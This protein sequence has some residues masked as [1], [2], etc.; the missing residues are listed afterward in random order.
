M[1]CVDVSLNWLIML[2][3]VAVCVIYHLGVNYVDTASRSASQTLFLDKPFVPKVPM[4]R[5]KSEWY[6]KSA[7]KT[8]FQHPRH[9]TSFLLESLK[10]TNNGTC[11]QD[12]QDAC[13]SVTEQITDLEV[14][15]TENP[16]AEVCISC[17][18]LIVHL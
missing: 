10:G 13:F 6:H 8:L 2:L 14:F 17:V 18:W 1:P 5:E 4:P 16:A 3:Y 12:K 7:T 15:G 11:K 9:N